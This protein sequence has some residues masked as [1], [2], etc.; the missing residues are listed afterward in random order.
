M[1]KNNELEPQTAIGPGTL[2]QEET[3]DPKS[4]LDGVGDTEY[5]ELL[6]PLSVAFVAQAAL[7]TN[8]TAPMHVGKTHEDAP[9]LTRSEN[10]IRQIYGFDLRAQAQQ[11]GKTHVLKRIPIESGKTIRL[12]GGEAQVVLRQLT[13][14]VLQREGKNNLIANAHARR[15]VEGRIVQSRG[16]LMSVLGRSPLSVRDQ[17]QS[18]L[19]EV[20]ESPS[21]NV[22]QG[23]TYGPEFP[24]LN[25]G[26]S[27]TVGADSTE[28][29]F[30]EPTPDTPRKRGKGR[31][32]A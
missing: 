3:T 1:D 12:L 14:A 31:R 24:G 10:D 4:L 28:G 5:V 29:N 13:T 18:A 6:N 15:E 17:L 11:S 2:T 27:T 20:S 23:D 30:S 32:S 22:T 21:N 19:D 9:G 16:D 7:T 8:V 26:S 25:E